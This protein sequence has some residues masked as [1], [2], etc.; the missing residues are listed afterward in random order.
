MGMQKIG[1]LLPSVISTSALPERPKNS[2]NVREIAALVTRLLS[3]YWT[4]DEPAAVRE[5]QIEDWL[6]DLHEFPLAL[7]EEAYRRGARGN[8]RGLRP[9]GISGVAKASAP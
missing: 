5:A 1:E 3:H 4:A 8:G 9:A 7:I 6:D 2:S